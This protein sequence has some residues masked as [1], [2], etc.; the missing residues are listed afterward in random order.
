LQ[1]VVGDGRL[2]DV[3]CYTSTKSRPEAER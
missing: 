1:M 2:H 3:K